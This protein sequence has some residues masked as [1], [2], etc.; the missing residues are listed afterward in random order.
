M[1]DPTVMR[2]LADVFREINSL[3]S[4]GIIAEYALGGSR[5]RER[6]WQMLESGSVD[7]QTLRALLAAHGMT[8]D[9][10]DEK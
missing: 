3:K 4:E 7:R 10:G 6:A 9:I 8:E 5:R 2:T 1:I